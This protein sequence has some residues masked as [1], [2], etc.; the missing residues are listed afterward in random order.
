MPRKSDV[1][2]INIAINNYYQSFNELISLMA[3]TFAAMGL[4][5]T[6]RRVDTYNPRSVLEPG[7]FNIVFGHVTFAC[8]RLLDAHAGAPFILW[9]LEQLSRD[10]GF[11]PRYPGYLK[12]LHRATRLW[13]YSAANADVLTSWGLPRAQVLPL[14]YDPALQTVPANIEKDLDVCFFGT[15]NPRR[16][17]IIERLNRVGLRVE[18]RERCYGDERNMLLARSHIALNVHSFENV[19]ILEEARISFLLANGCFVVSENSDHDPYDGGVIFAPADRLTE[20][21]LHWLAQPAA[22]RA[23]IAARGTA[24]LKRQPFLPALKEALEEAQPAVMEGWRNYG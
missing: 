1:Y 2:L 13:D 7:A 19:Q 12:L 14:G 21:C 17:T 15:L 18:A 3:H 8:D 22:V 9:Q 16:Q 24:A 23:A 5:C 20:T 10:D 4:Q 11:L 6:A